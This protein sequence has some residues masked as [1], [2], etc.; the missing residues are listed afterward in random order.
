MRSIITLAVCVSLPTVSADEV[1]F[2]RDVRPILSDACFTCH[3]PDSGQREADLR[4][5]QQEGIFR[6]LGNITIVDAKDPA[7]SE[8]LR[9]IESSDPDVVMPPAGHGRKLSDVEKQTIRLW[10]EQGATW[11]GHW[12][13]IRPLRPEVPQSKISS[14]ANDVDRFIQ[15]TLNQRQL[16]PLDQAAPSTLVRRLSFDLTGLP[17]TPEQVSDFTQNPSAENWQKLIDRL[18]ASHHYAERMTAFWLDLVRY[19]DTNGIHG[20]NHR[21]IWMYRDWVL[22]AFQKNMPFD[23]F[24]IEQL[25]G[26]L[27]PNATDEQRIASGYNRLLMTTRE[28]GAQA[29]E[30]LAKYSADRV[31]NA[32][33]VWL[34]ATMTCCE[35]HDHKF[36]PYSIRDFYQFAAFFADVKDVPVGTQPTVKMP[37]R[38]QK[39]QRT[40]LDQAVA[41]IQKE[42]DTQTP[43]LDQSLAQ[44]ALDLQAKQKNSPKVWSPSKVADIKSKN[45]Q[46]LELL[47]DNSVLTSGK[48][49]EHDTYTIGITPAEGKVAAIRLETLR[50]DSFARQSLARGNGNF[51]LSGIKITHVRGVDSSEE[52]IAIKSAIASYEQKDWPVKNSLDGNEATGWAVDGHTTSDK[53]PIAVFRF[54]NAVTVETEDRFIV[55]LQH[56]AVDHH[57]IGRFR[58]TTTANPEAGTDDNTLGIPSE[59]LAVIENWPTV[60]EAARNSLA[61]HYRSI[62]P[63]LADARSQLT[64]KKKAI[65]ELEKSIPQTLVTQ[66]QAPREIRVLARGNWMDDSGDIVQPAVPH[67]LAQLQSETRPTRLDLAKWFVDPENPLVA[68]VFVNRLWKL[69]FGE[70]IVQSADDFGSQGSW[71]TH[72]ELLDWLSVEF[73]ESGWDVQHLVRLIVSS[74]A[75]RRSS[76]ATPE[77]I[78]RDP[79]NDWLARQSRFRLDAEFIRDAALSVS[80]LLVDQSGGRSVKPYQPA[81]YWAHL[82][83]PKRQWQPD[84]GANQYRRGLYTYWCRTFLHPAMRSF[85]APTREECTVDRPRSNNSLQALVLL[86]DPSYVESARGLASRVLAEGG[87]TAESRIQFIFQ[88]CLS[89]PP[90]PAESEVVLNL[91]AQAREDFAAEQNRAEAFLEIGQ[92]PLPPNTNP[93]E[94]AA[95]TSVARAILN[96]HETI[97]R[98]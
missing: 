96:L 2:N 8:L 68:R 44:W 61:K 90:R 1:D 32:S 33:T 56:A 13:Y 95:W 11:K 76:V 55:E 49:P 20:D 51:V 27:L 63:L 87:G 82:N 35:C 64:A 66:T 97:T 85:D 65:E 50:H 54:V 29:K 92:L 21:E 74:D 30:Y 53:D 45:G 93:V 42:L 4:L 12:S 10:I 84:I 41:E 57:N 34:G 17:P 62:A 70:G 15:H 40:A 37:S 73:Q 78:A 5:D 25:A 28:G 89:R 14:T 75:Y 24:T 18:L 19:A 71:P 81:G 7:R 47:E 39:E 98:S 6:T 58:L 77:L 67:F 88:L 22:G 43:E 9:R 36:D 86:N 83:F 38:A 59:H 16:K 23:Q 80:G 46:V 31:R 91:L 52:A 60:D 79:F 94:L 48:H 69:L 26:D 72:P 3:G